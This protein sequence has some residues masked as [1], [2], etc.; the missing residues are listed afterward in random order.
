MSEHL[1]EFDYKWQEPDSRITT[2][3]DEVF[4]MKNNIVRIDTASTSHHVRLE[5]HQQIIDVLTTE[6]SLL[7]LHA[8]GKITSEQLSSLL[9]MLGSVDP[10]NHVVAHETIK[11]LIKDI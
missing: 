5:D 1:S 3:K 7:K 2:L 10:E 8:L 9:K 4:L 6:I 11:N